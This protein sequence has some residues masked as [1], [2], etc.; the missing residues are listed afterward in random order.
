MPKLGIDLEKQYV[1]DECSNVILY[2]D[3][4]KCEFWGKPINPELYP[5]ASEKA[6]W[7]LTIF[8]QSDTVREYVPE[9]EPKITVESERYYY[10]EERVRKLELALKRLCQKRN[11]ERK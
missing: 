1:C 8:T 11:R 3:R 2:W 4:H 7:W 5:H 9:P 10:L 6:T